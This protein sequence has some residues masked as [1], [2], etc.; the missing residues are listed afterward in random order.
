MSDQASTGAMPDMPPATAYAIRAWYTS[1]LS[2][3]QA[4]RQDLLAQVDSAKAEV[5]RLT[6]QV[7][8]SDATIAA[9]QRVLD[10]VDDW[11]RRLATE[12]ERSTRS[13][14]RSQTRSGATTRRGGSG[15]DGPREETAE[16]KPGSDRD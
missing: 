3:T 2:Q 6:K 7:K 16:R 9:L 8:R 4:V 11:I 5:D 12:E 10:T 14:A 15:K 1:I 13:A